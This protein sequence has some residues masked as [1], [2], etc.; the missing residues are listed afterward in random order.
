[1]FSFL[2]AVLLSPLP[3]PESEHLV[4]VL[5]ES[6]EG[7]KTGFSA[8]SFLDWRLQ[9]EVFTELSAYTSVNSDLTLK[10]GDPAERVRCGLVSANYFNMLRISPVL[11]RSF[12]LDNEVPGREHVVILTHRF[13]HRKFNSDPSVLGA[14]LSLNQELYTIVGVL[15]PL[16][17]FERGSTDLWIPLAF[18]PEH[19]RPGVQFFGV[20]ARLKSGVSVQQARDRIRHIAKGLDQQGRSQNRG[21]TLSIE[22]L[23]DSI[24]GVEVRRTLL[25]LMAA[26]VLVSLISV[27]NVANIFLSR[28]TNRYR[29][30]AIRAALGAGRSRLFRQFLSESLLI[31]AFGG[32]LGLLLAFWL[33]KAF[34]LLL[35]H[36]SL[37]NEID[38]ALNYRILVFAGG[39]SVVV[40]ILFA[41]LPALHAS[42][43]DLCKAMREQ[44]MQYS[45]RLKKSRS[46]LV[47]AQIATT[48]IL[49]FVATLLGLSF[50]RLLNV[51]TGFH[52][53]HVLTLNTYLGKTRYGQG[54]RILSYQSAFLERLRSLSAVT[55]AGV[56]N[57]L[58]LGGTGLNSVVSTLGNPAGPEKTMGVGIRVVSPQYQETMGI[59]L[60]K[61]RPLSEFDKLDTPPVVVVS[62]SVASGLWSGSDAIG[63]QIGVRA[64][65]LADMRF[66]VVGVTGNVKHSGLASESAQEIYLSYTQL[67]EP[68]VASFCRSPAFVVRTRQDPAELVGAVQTVAA[69]IDKDQPM[70]GI[71]TMDKVLSD[72]VTQPRF[73]ALLFGA[74]GSLAAALTAVGVYGALAYFVSLRTREIGIRIALGGRRRDIIRLVI[75][76]GMILT[77]AGLTVGL[78]GAIAVSRLFSSFLF[79]ISPIDAPTFAIVTL[80]ILATAMVA[81]LV[82]TLRA[83]RVDPLVVLRSE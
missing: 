56:T 69:L 16:K 13:W 73:R 79:G 46:I 43:L 32:C 48:C 1:M 39:S 82:P 5:E 22:S 12:D 53:D 31:S 17:T 75:G 68:A 18:R 70:Y 24:V 72:S 26:V 59:S 35:P 2:D 66:T 81:C 23:R 8:L 51:Q 7:R 34:L 6:P 30:V 71:Q 27:C 11:G 45:P 3:Y 52:S 9:S 58:P 21:W 77:V 33:M 50:V 41:I 78:G 47:V 29:E 4:S 19:L 76:H 44:T 49:L 64:E 57:A 20:W 25:L 28:A 55:S 10:A 37:P 42:R 15:P 60:V 62:Q 74:L 65:Y 67:P 36:S 80:L 38:V 61:G 40:G 83:T 54:H 14:T 63:N